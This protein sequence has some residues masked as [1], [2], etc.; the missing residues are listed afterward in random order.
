MDADL[1]HH[2]KYIIDFI[3]KQRA[4]NADIVSG[5]RYIQ[6]A[7]VFGWNT[8]RKLTSRVANFIAST[9]L[10]TNYSDLTG[11]FRLYKKEV[12]SQIIGQVVSKG[13]AFQMEILIRAGKQDYS[14]REVP[15]VFVD[16]L[17]GQSKLGAN[18]IKTYLKGVFRLFMTF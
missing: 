13:Y 17:Y 11:S 7:G 1:S 6:G 4:T 9:A 3:N 8:Y 12:L 14:I 16:R 15:I 5:T 2:P 18:E 10:G